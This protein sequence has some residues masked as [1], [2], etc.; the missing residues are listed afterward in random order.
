M[1]TQKKPP[2]PVPAMPVPALSEWGGIAV[3]DAMLRAPTIV[4]AS[5]ALDE[6]I[7]ALRDADLE[8]GGQ[9]HCVVKHPT[10][11]RYDAT[12]FWRR[13]ASERIIHR[14]AGLS[15][16]TPPI[17]PFRQGSTADDAIRCELGV[18]GD[19]PNHQ[20]VRCEVLHAHNRGETSVVVTTGRGITP[21]AP[22]H[23]D[24]ARRAAIL[25]GFAR[26]CLDALIGDGDRMSDFIA[27]SECQ[28]VHVLSLCPDARF[29]RLDR[30]ANQA[31]SPIARRCIEVS[32]HRDVCD[33]FAGG[34]NGLLLPDFTMLTLSKTGD[35]ISIGLAPAVH[36]VSVT[37]LDAMATLRAHARIDAMG[38]EEIEP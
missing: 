23:Q 27:D 34:R 2:R 26:S 36:A 28:T 10:E 21:L 13:K 17:D 18:M 32:W 15:K 31:R 14:F 7:A 9:A 30:I 24:P 19:K 3:R 12:G 22:W 20:P 25:L 5:D 4:E 33:P 37:G 38:Y 1:S 8:N 29:R 16:P 11:A 35:G 6:A